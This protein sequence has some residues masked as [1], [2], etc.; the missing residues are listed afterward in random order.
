MTMGKSA[1]EWELLG[2]PDVKGYSKIC[3]FVNFPTSEN[4]IPLKN[5]N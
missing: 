5:E 4:R 2:T 3:Q 1:L